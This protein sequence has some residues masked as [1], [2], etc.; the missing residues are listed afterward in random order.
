MHGPLRVQT[1]AP[2]PAG[3]A[4]AEHERVA[5]G[6]IDAGS[7]T[8]RPTRMPIS[9]GGP[10]EVP[11]APPSWMSDPGSETSV[12]VA[13]VLNPVLTCCRPKL[14][15][16]VTLKLPAGF[17]ALIVIPELRLKGRPALSYP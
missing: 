13:E 2:G 7:G 17:G 12:K 11:V 16:A 14:D 4:Q 5:I 8:A 10:G 3:H 15:E 1:L 6:K 9:G